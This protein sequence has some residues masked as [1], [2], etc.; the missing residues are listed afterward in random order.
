MVYRVSHMD[1][2][3]EEQKAPRDDRIVPSSPVVHPSNYQED[4]VEPEGPVDLL[5]DVAMTRRRPTWLRD[6]LQDAVRHASPHDT[7]REIKRP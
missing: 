6:T 5:R 3:C 7:F 1:I 4:S 2:D